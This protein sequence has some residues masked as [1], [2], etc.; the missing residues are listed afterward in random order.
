MTDYR[1]TLEKNLS[2][3]RARVAAA[4]ERAGRAADE[5]R[6]I[7]VTKGHPLAAVEACLSAEIRDVAENRVGELEVKAAALDERISKG[8]DPGGPGAGEGDSTRPRWHMVGHIQR[9]KASR[10]VPLAEWI[11]SLDSLRL[12]RKLSAE[13]ED[14]GLEKRSVLVQ[15]NTSGEESKYGF[16]PEGFR[17]ALDELLEQPRLDVAGLMTMAPYTDDE[18]VLRRTFRGLRALHEEAREHPGYEG[19]ELSMG[20]T[21]DFEIAVEEGS[22]MIR[23]GTALF[24]ERPR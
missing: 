19:R 14:A 13:A 1:A 21:N 24:G 20:M 5:V 3:V 2:E 12:A 9:R 15:V 8:R 18:D 11:H 10:V 22:T 23:I 16:T 17:D 6:L 4:A 7:A